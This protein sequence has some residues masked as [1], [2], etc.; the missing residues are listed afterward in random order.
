ME[1]GHKVA[2]GKPD[3]SSNSGIGLIFQLIH[4]DG[5]QFFYNTLTNYA[6]FSLC[7]QFI[8]VNSVSLKSLEGHTL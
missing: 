2:T 5:M 6:K 4:H 7:F 3:Q 1:P 8:S